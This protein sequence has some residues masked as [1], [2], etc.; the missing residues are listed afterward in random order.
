[1]W[2]IKSK[3]NSTQEHDHLPFAQFQRSNPL[4]LIFLLHKPNQSSFQP[5]QNKLNKQTHMQELIKGED[6]TQFMNWEL[7]IIQKLSPAIH[8]AQGLHH[9]M[10]TYIPL[11]F[12]RRHIFFGTFFSAYFLLTPLLLPFFQW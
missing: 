11:Y 2:S 6:I 5:T 8:Q 3:K 10:K 1:M 7:K 12:H 9:W 4:V